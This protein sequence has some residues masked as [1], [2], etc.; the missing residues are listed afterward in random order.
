[1]D[2]ENIQNYSPEELESMY[3]MLSRQTNYSED[4]IKDKLIEH[5]FNTTNVIREYM[6]A[7]VKSASDQPIKSYNQEIYKQIRMKLDNAI[8][9]FNNKQHEKIRK[10]LAEESQSL[11]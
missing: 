7:S 8:R 3:G 5:N 6:G 1:M 4:E 11:K 9:D 10:E 2:S